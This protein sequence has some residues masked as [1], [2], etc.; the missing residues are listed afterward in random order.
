M[1]RPTIYEVAKIG[2]GRLSVM[3]KP[4]AGEWVNDEF[5]AI[6]H[7]GVTHILSLLETNEAYTVGLDA[8][9]EICNTH[10]MEFTNYEMLDRGIPS[11]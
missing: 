7:A 8:E 6:K 1:I 9:G 11:D 5:A 3:A 4:T 10:K 2:N